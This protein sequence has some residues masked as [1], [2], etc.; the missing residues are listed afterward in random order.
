M[1]DWTLYIQK[2]SHKQ[3]IR[4]VWRR[5]LCMWNIRVWQNQVMSIYA[6]QHHFLRHITQEVY[7]KYQENETNHTCHI[8][9]LQ[10]IVTETFVLKHQTGF[11]FMKIIINNDTHIELFNNI[12]TQQI[13]EWS[14]TLQRKKLNPQTLRMQ[15]G[16]HRLTLT[17]LNWCLA[18]WPCRWLKE[19]R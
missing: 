18:F 8:D 6:L 16:L 12:K 15:Q 7:A 2:G 1:D 13:L 11:Y 19:D 14:S 4:P 9:K 10:T 17:H 3:G 5:H